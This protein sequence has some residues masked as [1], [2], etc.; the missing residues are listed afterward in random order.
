MIFLDDMKDYI[1]GL[2]VD[3]PVYVGNMPPEPVTCIALY[4]YAGMPPEQGYTRTPGLQLL[5]RTAPEGYNASYAALYEI[6][7]ALLSIGYED[8]G[9][10][11]GFEINGTKYLRV[12]TPASGI[13][14]LGKD[15][16]GN[17]LFSK[18]FYV[19]ME[20]K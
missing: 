11:A 4:E 10:T 12:Y 15:D 2:G 16:N 17:P 19:V 1:D 7:D 18:N 13:N 20:D 8:G 9:N 14:P 5:M 6:N 3:I